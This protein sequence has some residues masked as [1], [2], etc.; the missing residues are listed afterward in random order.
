MSFKD[1]FKISIGYLKEQKIRSIL[2]ILATTIGLTSLTIVLGIN[3][4]LN[5]EIKI[6][7]KKEALYSYPIIIPK[8]KN[9]SKYEFK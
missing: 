5:E 9:N 6:T 3:N 2:T 7:R 8:E 4:G 1:I